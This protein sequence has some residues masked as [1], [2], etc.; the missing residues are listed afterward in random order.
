MKN[1]IKEAVNPI[2]NRDYF[3]KQLQKYFMYQ[4]NPK[5]K[6]SKLPKVTKLKDDD[7]FEISFIYVKTSKSKFSPAYNSEQFTDEW[8]L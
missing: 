8:G 7:S 5:D 3:Q 4:Y 6:E 1:E 2:F